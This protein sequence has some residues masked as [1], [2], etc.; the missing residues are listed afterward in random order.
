MLKKCKIYLL[1]FDFKNDENMLKM[2]EKIVNICYICIFWLYFYD[3]E[4]EKIVK[5]FYIFLA[6]SRRKYVMFHAVYVEAILL[7]SFFLFEMS[8][9]SLS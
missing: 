2:D 9:Q 4:T 8:L 7:H 5:I 1:F 3:F 6:Y